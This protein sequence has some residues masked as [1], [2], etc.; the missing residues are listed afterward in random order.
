M[1]PHSNTLAWKIPW[2]EEPGRLPSLGSWRVGHDWATSFSLLC[3]G[4]GNGSPLQCSCLENP[5]DGG[6]WWAA[7]YGVSQSWTWLKQLSSSREIPRHWS[8]LKYP[9]VILMCNWVDRRHWKSSDI[10]ERWVLEGEVLGRWVRREVGMSEVVERSRSLGD[11]I[12]DI[13]FVHGN[14]PWSLVAAA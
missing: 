14:R 4:E 13:G 11:N 1:A 7:V 12:E 10:R 9:Q 3:I 8:C 6:A 2:M 5:R